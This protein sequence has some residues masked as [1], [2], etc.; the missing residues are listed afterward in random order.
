MVWEKFITLPRY[1]PIICNSIVDVSIDYT[2]GLVKRKFDVNPITVEGKA[3]EYTKDD[4][5]ACFDRDVHW[6]NVLKSKW[7]PELIHVDIAQRTIIQKYYNPALSDYGPS[8]DITKTFPQL[9][10]QIIEMYKFFKKHNVFKNNGSLSNL[11]HNEDQ[12]IA[13]DF[14]WS[15]ERPEGLEEE[16]YSYDTWLSKISNTLPQKLRDIL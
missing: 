12:I 8:K 11:T 6:N 1:R 16:L 5:Q 3:H 7:V 15:T 13:F 10:E 14:K 2:S 4:V 9:E